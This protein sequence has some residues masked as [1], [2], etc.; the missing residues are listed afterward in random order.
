MKAARAT[1]KEGLS[2]R[3]LH[4]PTHRHRARPT[5]R[6]G[7]GQ[8]K[9]LYLNIVGKINAVYTGVLMGW[10]ITLGHNIKELWLK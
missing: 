10:E 6:R 5:A 9:T 2:R 4:P 7:Q 3:Q 1:T 8:G